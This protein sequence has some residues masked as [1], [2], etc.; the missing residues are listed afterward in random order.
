MEH[1]R[2]LRPALVLTMDMPKQEAKESFEEFIEQRH[3]VRVKGLG[4]LQNKDLLSVEDASI[5]AIH[6][7]AMDLYASFQ[8]E[9]NGPLK[10]YLI[11]RDNAG[12]YFGPEHLPEVQQRLTTLLGQYKLFA[13]DA[14]YTALI[15]DKKGKWSDLQRDQKR[16]RRS[17][18][19]NQEEIDDNYK[20]I[21]K[22]KKENLELERV[23]TDQADRSAKLQ[24]EIRATREEFQE[25]R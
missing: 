4:F 13:L 12:Q 15:A 7:G 25:I 5:D 23:L 3:N 22:L 18:S 11:G 14:Y 21:E 9:K 20:D 8:H 1:D 19:K 17:L 24:E 10:V 2:S 6:N 16:A